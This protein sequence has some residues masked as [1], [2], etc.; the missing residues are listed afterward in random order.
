MISIQSQLTQVQNTE[1]RRRQSLTLRGLWY[2]DSMEQDGDQHDN[3]E[4]VM[5]HDG[6]QHDNNENTIIIVHE[7][8]QDDNESIDMDVIGVEPLEDYHAVAGLDTTPTIT[9]TDDCVRKR[10]YR[11]NVNVLGFFKE[12]AGEISAMA[13]P[14]EEESFM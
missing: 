13:S 1:H 8:N 12:V 7:G 5:V 11:K 4:D 10:M 14:R 9:I 6:D 2:N 3:N